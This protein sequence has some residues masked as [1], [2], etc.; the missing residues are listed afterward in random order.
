MKN[1]KITQSIKYIKL[2]AKLS[3][4]PSVRVTVLTRLIKNKGFFFSICSPA[5]Q[6]YCF[7]IFHSGSVTHDIILHMGVIFPVTSL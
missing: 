6:I 7:N 3:H 2:V 1:H 4:Y 5:V